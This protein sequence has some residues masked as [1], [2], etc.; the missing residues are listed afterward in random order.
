MNPSSIVP[1]VN[2]TSVGNVGAI[3]HKTLV[4]PKKNK[5]S[6]PIFDPMIYLPDYEW[7]SCLNKYDKLFS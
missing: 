7:Y 6:I 4:S 2:R 3:A 1:K 5:P